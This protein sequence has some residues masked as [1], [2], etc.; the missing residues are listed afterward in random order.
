MPVFAV[1]GGR[2]VLIDGAETRDRLL[3]HTPAAKVTF[4]PEGRH[5]LPG[6][7]G[8][9]MDFLLEPARTAAA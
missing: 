5:F 6:Q 7:T 9:V 2:D 3:R 8:P 1:V 4:L